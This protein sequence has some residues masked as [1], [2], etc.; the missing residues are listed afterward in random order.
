MKTLVAATLTFTFCLSASAVE[1][2]KAID[3]AGHGKV[4]VLQEYKSEKKD[5]N[6]QNELESVV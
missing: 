6:A 3:A 5:L 4:A 1:L 2:K